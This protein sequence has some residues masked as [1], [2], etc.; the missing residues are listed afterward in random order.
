[1][2]VTLED[3]AVRKGYLDEGEVQEAM[4]I[5]ALDATKNERL[6]PLKQV[7]VEHGFLSKLQM[8]DLESEY[9]S[10]L[11]NSFDETVPEEVRVMM[12]NKDNFVDKFVLIRTLGRGGM[13]EVWKA[14]DI[15]LKRYVA[16]KFIENLDNVAAVL[17]EARILARLRHPNIVDVYEIGENFIVMQYIDGTTL[18]KTKTTLEEALETIRK[19]CLA[20]DYAHSMG[21]IHRDIKPQNVMIE[22]MTKNVYIMDFGI[23]KWLAEFASVTTS[24]VGTPSYMSPEQVSGP[25]K[26]VDSRTDIY[27][28]G[29]MLYTIITGRPPFSAESM[30]E[31]LEKIEN[32]DPIPPGK[33]IA[34]IPRDVDSI[35]LKAMNKNKAKRY[36]SGKEFA[37]DIERAQKG[38]PVKATHYGFAAKFARS[39]RKNRIVVAALFLC[40]AAS[41]IGTVS[42][43]Y[44]SDNKK[45]SAQPAPITMHAIPQPKFLPPADRKII[46]RG[47][48][49]KKY[50]LSEK[51][52]RELI[53]DIRVRIEDEYE[54]SEE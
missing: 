36:G 25:Q 13:G 54:N 43:F 15:V 33:I 41:A 22:N 29:A 30:S 8:E 19:V 52:M 45:G 31:L 11:Q 37:D 53:E 49:A 5:Q 18:D 44:I 48:D 17:K 7:L 39:I 24:I 12:H 42:G 27:A 38:E 3:I 20:I 4:I 1:M 6:V 16:I 14:Y 46:I 21:V 35:I 34:G 23:A 28:L 50:H 51:E 26:Y 40:A 32:E 47:E 9:V 10:E 2:A